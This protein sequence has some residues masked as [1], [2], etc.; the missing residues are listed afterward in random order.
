MEVQPDQRAV[1]QSINSAERF[2]EKYYPSFS[3]TVG[4]FYQDD[5]KVIWNGNGFAG[6]QFKTQVLPQLQAALASFEVHGFDTHPLG[7][8]TL[9]S[10][11]GV[12]RIGAKK[13][14]FAQTFVLQRSG[15]LTYI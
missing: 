8:N 12:V 10:V 1:S 7:D 4:K 2:I 14:Q 15:S 3:R 11:S 6:S 13:M 9:V 5:T